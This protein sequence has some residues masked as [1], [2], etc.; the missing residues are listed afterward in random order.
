MYY[1]AVGVLAI[2][3]LL[4]VNHDILLNRSADF[5]KPA[6]KVYRRFLFTVLIYYIADVLWGALEYRKLA[7][8]LFADTTIY[9][10]A[11]AAGVLFWAQY[12]IVYLEDRTAF[13][14]LLVYAG[15]FI[16]GFISILAIVNIFAPVLFTVDSDCVYR[17]LPI[18]YVMLA[19][20][21]LLLLLI[22]IFATTS[23]V[24]RDAEKRPKY[25]TLAFFGLIMGLFLFIQLWYPYLP[26]Y[27]IAYIL[28]T[29]LLHTFVINE[30]KE[31]YRKKLEASYE[32]QRRAGTIS[33]HIAMSLARDYMALFYVNMDTDE[34]IEYHTDDESGVLTEAR[35]GTDFFE[36]CKREVKLFV[37][38]EDN[39]AFLKA[40]NRQFL[41]ETLARNPVF[42]QTYR[43]I[44]GGAPFYVRMK[45]S[46]MKDDDRYIVIGVT[47]IDEQVKQR[48]AEEQMKEERV[49]YNRI[50]ALTGSF[51]AMY[52]V[53]PETEHYREFGSS[54]G[55]EERYNQMRE[56]ENFFETARA[57][58][59]IY[60]YPEDVGLFLSI[61][62]KENVMAE[63]ERSGIF[64]LGYRLNM[65]GKPI[66]VLLK[67]AMIEER[68]GRR[69]IVGINDVEAQIRQEEEYKRNLAQA[70]KQAKIDALTGVKN[71]HAYLET[72]ACMNSRIAER[73]QPPF[74]VVMLDI[75]DLK[76]VNDTAGHQ[77]GDQYLR[78][79]CK[80]I[81]DT[82]I[83]SPVFRIGG[84]EFVVISQG[85]DYACIDELL[86]KIH[87]HNAEAFRTGGVMVACGMARFE[88]DAC[89]ASVFERADHSMY[90]NKKAMKAVRDMP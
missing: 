45:V 46:R 10:V 89:V 38:P 82:F 13:G 80:I 39:E 49:T 33:A 62:T 36:S 20:Q 47:D 75:N 84:D 52:A 63:I 78:D 5:R 67:A 7:L 3:L 8:L 60:N 71:K 50:Y 17:A 21:I 9:F 15:R 69:L 32:Q 53:D 27:T 23:I 48:R 68:E 72:E 14:K 1:S 18:R 28:G 55:Y 51:I 81:C 58:C 12:T 41:T 73:S 66:N 31:D 43:R 34:Y 74:A 16:A 2:I 86:G 54:D 70:Q 90:E 57:S 26:L 88:D 11:M 35:R 59:R 4:I 22:S 29:C 76:K 83:H 24:R 87:E 40:M 56:G 44:K 25:R 19:C 79:A 77:A 37:H 65:D 61:F 30:E 64:T 6:W 42:E 85:R